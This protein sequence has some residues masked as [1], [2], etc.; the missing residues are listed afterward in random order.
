MSTLYNDIAGRS[1]ERL[2]ALSDGVFAVAMTLL[3][4][5]L[6]V[7]PTAGIHSEGDL[8]RAIVALAPQLLLYIMSFMTLGIFWIGQQTQLNHLARSDRSLSWLHLGILCGVC[9][10]P[11]STHL[12]VDF[13]TYRLA[14]LLYWLN[15]LVL[16]GVLYAS[17]SCAIAT[18]LVKADLQPETMRAIR[19]RIIIAQTLYALGLALCLVKTT[20]S[21]V[22]F[23]GIQLNYVLAP[24]WKRSRRRQ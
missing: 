10:V 1:V 6:K 4:L 19:R 3:V 23:L 20:W 7:P 8:W 9:L 12:L 2:A 14:L 13:I 18:G 22:A 17:W 15:L 11:L 24:V 21:I 16:G 5:D